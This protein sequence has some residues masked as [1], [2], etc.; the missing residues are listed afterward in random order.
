ML[1]DK[2]F[3]EIMPL[4]ENDKHIPEEDNKKNLNEYS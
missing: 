4:E 1:K 3:N 2:E